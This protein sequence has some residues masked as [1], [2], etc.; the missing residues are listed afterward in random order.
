LIESAAVTPQLVRQRFLDVRHR[1]LIR[2]VGETSSHLLRLEFFDSLV[3]PPQ[4]ALRIA[5]S[6]D[7][8]AE[9]Q[10]SGARHDPRPERNG[11]ADCSFNILYVDSKVSR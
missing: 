8:L 3:Y 9:G 6:R 4:V 1:L 11:S 5:H 7:T 2:G 10:L